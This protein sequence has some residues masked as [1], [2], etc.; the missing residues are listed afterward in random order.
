MERLQL[1]AYPEANI[2]SES[3]FNVPALLADP[4]LQACFQETLRLRGQN[5]S[6]RYVKEATTIPVGGKDYYIR[7]GSTVFILA[8]LIHMDTDIYSNVHEFQPERFLDA[9]LEGALIQGNH[10]S[11]VKLEKKSGPPKF[12]KHGVPVR[13]YL[14]PFGGGENLVRRIFV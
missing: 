7:E 10:P 9:D 14:M 6:T 8:P 5:G 2:S 4:F 12:F 3:I 11:D 13:H 1:H